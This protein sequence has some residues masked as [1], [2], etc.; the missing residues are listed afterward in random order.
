MRQANISNGTTQRVK[1]GWHFLLCN[2]IVDVDNLQAFK[3]VSHMTPLAKDKRPLKSVILD[4]VSS[5]LHRK[6]TLASK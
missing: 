3:V 1:M 6:E 4:G 2:F 5:C